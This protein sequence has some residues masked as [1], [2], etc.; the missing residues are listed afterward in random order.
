M[1]SG[2]ENGYWS[3]ILS[4]GCDCIFDCASPFHVIGHFA[5]IKYI[6][7]HDCFI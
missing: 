7:C 3:W 2:E 5:G 1:D 6:D 4:D